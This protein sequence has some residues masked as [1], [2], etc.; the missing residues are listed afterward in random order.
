MNSRRERSG[1]GSTGCMGAFI[2]DMME[3]AVEP[4]RVA[5]ARDHRSI[6]Q[7]ACYRASWRLP[8][9]DFHRLA[10]ASFEQR[11]SGSLHITSLAFPF[12]CALLDTLCAAHTHLPSTVDQLRGGGEAAKVR[13]QRAGSSRVGGGSLTPRPSQNRT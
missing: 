13:P 4:L 9:P 8:G 5:I 12:A 2:S 1:L 10:A 3:Q 11:R 6:P 7:A